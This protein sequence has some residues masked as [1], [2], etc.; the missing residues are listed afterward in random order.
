M[1]ELTYKAIIENDLMK[2]NSWKFSILQIQSELETINAEYAAIKATN[3]DK[4]PSGSGDN[5]QEEKLVTAI[6]RKDQKEAELKLNRMRVAD[7]ERLLEQLTDDER[8]ILERMVINK[9]KYATDGLQEELGYERTQ[10]YNIKN[11]ALMHL[12]QLRHGAAYQP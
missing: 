5:L 3:Y 11:R 7:M 10:I 8:R 1:R 4:M 9:E 6:A 2:L 12:A